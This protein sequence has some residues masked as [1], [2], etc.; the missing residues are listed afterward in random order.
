M[1]ALHIINTHAIRCLSFLLFAA[2]MFTSPLQAQSD[3]KTMSARN[4]REPI[5]LDGFLNERAWQEAQPVDDFIQRELSEGAPS[6][7]K[8]EVRILYDENNIYIGVKCF[9][10]EPE[11]IIRREMKRDSELRDDDNFTVVLDTFRDSRT[12]YYFRTN[13][14]GARNDAQVTDG[15]TSDD[16]N[17]IWDAAAR[18]TDYGWSVE[19]VIPF[20]TLRF[21]NAEDQ[22][23][24]I[25]FRRIIRRKNEEA[26][27]TSWGRNDGLLQLS[28]SGTLTGLSQVKRSRQVDFKPYLL[29]GLEK[30][31]GIKLDDSFKYGL[32]VKYP[33]SSQLTL[34]LTTFTD[35]AQVESDREQI[36]LTRFSLHYPEKREFFLEGAEIFEFA[37]TYTTPFY[38]RRIGLTPDRE[39][40]RILGG[41][42]LIGRAGSYNIGIINMQT[43]NEN[44]HPATNYSVVRVKRDILKHS[45]VGII[46][47]NIYNSNKYDSRTFGA[48]FLY[49][50][51]S[52]MGNQNLE[53]GGYIAQDQDPEFDNGTRAGRVRLGM[54]NDEYDIGLLYH[55]VGE[56]YTPDVGYVRRGGIRHHQ[57]KIEYTPRINIPRVKKLLFTVIDLNYYTDTGSRLL[58]RTYNYR[59]IGILFESGDTVMLKAYGSY[60][61]LDQPFDIF[62]DKKGVVTIPKGVYSWWDYEF[63]VMTAKSRSAYFQVHAH[64]G[65]FW[66]GKRTNVRTVLGLN[67]SRYYS[68][69]TDVVYNDITIRGRRFHANAL[70][71]RVLV[72]LTT[73]LNASTLLQ[74]NNE[75]NRVN[76][77]ARIHFI[78]RIGS[79]FYL[80]YNHLWDEEDHYR[81]IHNTGIFKMA[82]LIKF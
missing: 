77:N 39:Q 26:L 10:S 56:H 52:F 58:T 37:S 7:E 72:N 6:T 51:H 74:W 48:D 11:K 45:Y 23:W 19:I 1:D 68:L 63:E 18:V 79:D 34:D 14:N 44:N 43:D 73:R 30:T 62:K 71:G 28:K 80:V 41:A 75:T 59:P 46:A 9:D 66:D 49:R 31:A 21:P 29:G 8:T 36:N 15:Q 82:Y 2:S 69:E 53:F 12:G 3:V 32:D 60:E 76:M 5:I 78:P 65:T 57:A 54:N 17:G 81:T 33:L 22:E 20:K 27:W 47:T 13:P 16:W 50:T 42:K 61:Y 70:G 64:R 35:F 67:T 38:S 24:G 55:G 4:V 40:V 25:N